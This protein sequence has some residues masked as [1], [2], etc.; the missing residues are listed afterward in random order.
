[1]GYENNAYFV[2]LKTE[3]SITVGLTWKNQTKEEP[4]IEITNEKKMS[5][6]L[7]KLNDRL[8]K[9]WYNIIL[10]IEQEPCCKNNEKILLQ[11]E[12][13][14]LLKFCK[15]TLISFAI[16][17]CL[18][19][20]YAFRNLNIVPSDDSNLSESSVE[21]EKLIDDTSSA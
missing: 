3:K 16:L 13:I 6:V 18:I 8:I 14:H 17:L 9:L 20:L 12:F 2:V 15:C 10:G 7:A 1:M 11:I 19:E 4:N 21:T 5:I